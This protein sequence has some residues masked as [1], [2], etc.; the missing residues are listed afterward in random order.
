MRLKTT[1]EL[2]I[3]SFKSHKTLIFYSLEFLQSEPMSSEKDGV[4][5]EI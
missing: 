4:N 5:A 1:D 2:K 3:C